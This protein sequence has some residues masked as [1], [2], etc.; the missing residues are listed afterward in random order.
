[1]ELAY[2][3]L[4]EKIFNWV[5]DKIFEPIFKWL[6]GLLNTVFTWIFNEIL[7]PILLPILEDVMNFMFDLYMSIYSNIIYSLFSGILKL[8]DYMEIAFDV[9]IGIRDVRY[10]P[11]PSNTQNV[12]TGPLIDVLLK[13]DTVSRAFWMITMAGITIA[14]LLAVFATA[15]SS[16]DL[17]FENKRPVTKVLTALMKA[18]IQFFMVPFF[19][20]VMLSLS[21]EILR[22]GTK[23]VTGDIPTTLGRIVFVIASLNAAKSPQYN[24]NY[25]KVKASDPAPLTIFG[26]EPGDPVRYPFYITEKVGNVNPLDYS[27]IDSVRTYFDLSEF[28]YL[29]GILAAIFLLFVMAVC[30]ITFVKRIFEIILLYLVSPYFVSTMPLDDGERFGRWREMFIGKCFTGFGSAIG[31]RLYLMVCRMIMGNTIQFTSTT[32]GSSIEMD[33]IM[34][35]FFLIGGAWAVFKSGPMVTSLIS[36]GA[37]SQESMT[38]SVAGAALYGNTIGKV[39]SAGASLGNKLLFNAFRGKS[40][41]SARARDKTAKNNDPA[42][43]FDGAKLDKMSKVKPKA[44]SAVKKNSALKARE[45]AHRKMENK[46]LKAADGRKKN[47]AAVAA[48]AKSAERR[49]IKPAAAKAKEAKRRNAMAAKSKAQASALSKSSI[50]TSVATGAQQAYKEKKNFQLGSIF[51][52]TYDA[53]GNHKIRVLGFGVDKD[54]NGNTMAFKMPV[55]NMKFQKTDPKESMKLARMNIPGI[56]SI[57]SNVQNGKL[58]YSDIS[59]LG[60]AYS[61][62]QDDSGSNTRILGGLGQYQKDASGTHVGVMG[63]HSH[64]YND[65]SSGVDVGKLQIR[66]GKN[67]NTV[68]C[69]NSI[70]FKTNG[71]HL[72]SMKIGSL[73]YSR[74]GITKSTPASTTVGSAPAGSTTT[75]QVT[76][77]IKPQVTPQASATSA[78]SKITVPQK[79]PDNGTGTGGK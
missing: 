47:A 39:A 78:K 32:V 15:K 45:G 75:K 7:S 65:G 49:K 37:G 33:Y 14:F 18:F 56:T 31:M 3:G 10:Y 21:A 30:L 50:P 43:K 55:M 42:Q 44:G 77:Q 72:Q 69:G 54:A 68:T 38:Q 22:A 34:K 28:D 71:E 73:Q 64:S 24:A 27:N 20:Y 52:S 59:V 79:K 76:P 11:D 74:I 67:G 63:I 8:I 17:D 48:M 35:L 5:L 36:M 12:I 41:E 16:L 1:M 62:H 53:N 51:K 40:G 25:V 2:L 23:A 46:K 4:F 19:V 66:G 60:G 58:Q 13:Q 57:N 9:F 61:Y 6:S 70:S 26:T 29:I